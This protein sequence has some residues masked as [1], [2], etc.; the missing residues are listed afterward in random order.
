MLT[1]PAATLVDLMFERPVQRLIDELTRLPG[2]G[3]KSAQRLAFHLL[4]VEEADARGLAQAIVDL[5]DQTSFCARCYN[6]T[7][8]VECSIC[9]DPRRDPSVVCVVE[10]AQDIAVIERTRE[11]DGQYHVLGGALSP[12]DGIGPAQ[13][14]VEELHVRLEELRSRVGPQPDIDTADGSF[15][16]LI[17]ATN[18]TIEGDTTAMYLARRFKP[19]GVTVTRPGIGLPVGG[20]M[21]Y[22]DELTLGRALMGRREI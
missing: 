22:A 18:P 19:L 12:I 17:V 10:R 16:E 7:S 13:L 21:D 15:A 14:R 11:F 20:D 9:L 8:G 2:V 6:V 5:R 1:H 4:N 3:R